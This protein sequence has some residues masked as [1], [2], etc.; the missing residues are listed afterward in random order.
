MR[1]KCKKGTGV[2]NLPKCLA[3]LLLYAAPYL[4]TIME[5]LQ[6][7]LMFSFMCL[8]LIGGPPNKASFKSLLFHCL[9]SKVGASGAWK[10]SPRHWDAIPQ[11]Y[12]PR[13]YALSTRPNPA[14]E[15]GEAKKWY[16]LKL[17]AQSGYCV[18]FT[19]WYYY[20]LFIRCMYTPFV[21]CTQSDS[22]FSDICT[23]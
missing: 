15:E 20:I 9:L 13:A 21:P 16:M 6:C 19:R 7:A 5:G 23:S 14:V 12:R 1:K 11:L 4:H 3:T 18:S 2:P 8:P 17:Q 10:I 22:G